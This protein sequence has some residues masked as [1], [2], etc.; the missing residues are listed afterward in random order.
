MGAAT[1][2]PLP[3][4]PMS[5]RAR[6]GRGIA[7]ARFN[8][9][10]A[11]T[12]AWPVGCPRC[13]PMRCLAPGGIFASTPFPSHLPSVGGRKGVKAMATLTRSI[14][15]DAPVDTVFDFALD[16]GRLCCLLYTS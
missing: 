2:R 7:S 8:G 13:G 12:H 16:I 3:D 14:T 10:A 6:F 1:Y 11:V 15:I 5:V 9:S 4:L